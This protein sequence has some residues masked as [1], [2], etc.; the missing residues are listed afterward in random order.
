METIAIDK[1]KTETKTETN[2][3]LLQYTITV[4]I[5]VEAEDEEA[6]YDEAHD[7]D[8]LDYINDVRN[9]DIELERA[10]ELTEDEW[11]WWARKRKKSSAK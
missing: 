7:T 9:I 10:V 1:T 11:A 4:Q 2:K 3:Y 6:A 5:P 8:P